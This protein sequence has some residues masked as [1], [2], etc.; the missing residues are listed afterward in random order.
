MSSQQCS[1]IVDP[2]GKPYLTP[3]S[4]KVNVNTAITLT[5]SLNDTEKGN[6]DY[7][8]QWQLANQKDVIV[9]D[10]QESNVFN[11]FVT[12]VQQECCYKCIAQNNPYGKQWISGLY[13][14]SIQLEIFGEK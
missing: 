9:S 5:C 4:W 10:W 3:S 12:N 1:G 6:P 13:S 2:P 8:Y 11:L 14:D 7:N